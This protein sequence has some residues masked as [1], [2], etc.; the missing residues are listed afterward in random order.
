ME[1]GERIRQTRLE[2]GLSQRALCGEKI[3]RN[4]LSLI[5]HGAAKPSVATLRYL[6]ERLGKP[7]SYFLGEQAASPNCACMEA[8]RSAY[9]SGDGAAV[10]QSLSEYCA[11]DP[12]CDEEYAL[13]QRL[14][15]LLMAEK[16]LASNQAPYASD[17]L[18]QMGQFSCLYWA[19]PLERARLLLLARAEPQSL[20]Q[21]AAQLPS[22][23]EA[24][25]VRAAAAFE[26]GEADACTRI[27]DAAQNRDCPEWC[28]L[29]AQALKATQDYAR[30]AEF[31]QRAQSAMPERVIPMLEECYRELGDYKRAYEYACLGRK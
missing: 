29:Y 31:Y 5:E 7:L 21:I 26:R 12:T 27:L 8:A 17:L 23:D 25:L 19:K 28:Y 2:A 11:P 1:L 13:L 20:R 4:M 18:A 22:D 10:L 15:R 3:T 16:A 6:A 30:A 24:L 9:A 14:G